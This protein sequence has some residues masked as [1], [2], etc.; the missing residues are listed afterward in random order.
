MLFLISGAHELLKGDACPTLAELQSMEIA[1]DKI[2]IIKEVAPDWATF[3]YQLNFDSNGKQIELFKVDHRSN[4]IDGCT[5]MFQHWLKGNG[6]KPTSWRTLARL[7]DTM[8][9][10]RLAT[11]LRVLKSISPSGV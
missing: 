11:S 10:K 2:E 9:Y 5:A 7:L 8:N 4:A 6:E 3:G 1:G